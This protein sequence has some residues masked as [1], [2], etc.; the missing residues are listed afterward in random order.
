MRDGDNN[1]GLLVLMEVVEGTFTVSGC[2]AGLRFVIGDSFTIG[3]ADKTGSRDVSNMPLGLFSKFSVVEFPAVV[4]VVV[5]DFNIA[6]F[7]EFIILNGIP[8]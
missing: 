3:K 7:C 8:V 6:Q 4:T 2:D 1:G 5:V